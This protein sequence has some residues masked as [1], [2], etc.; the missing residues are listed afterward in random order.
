VTLVTPDV[1]EDA[2]ID[3]LERLH[4]EHLAK[5]ERDRGLAARTIEK[6]QTVD[7]LIGDGIRL[8]ED[9]PPAALLGVFGTDR[10]PERDKNHRLTF[11]W[12]LAV[13]VTVVGTNRRDVIKRRSWYAMTV[14]ECLLERLPRHADPIDTLELLDV[15]FTNGRT[16]DARPRTVGEA[17]I[18]L[19]VRIR[20]SMD[21]TD[22]PPSDT[23]L[24]PGTPGGPP[25]EPYTPPEPWPLASDVTSTVD[26][27]PL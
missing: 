11:I 7:L 14:A 15:D 25:A 16:T 17:Q 3:V 20:E 4:I 22:L 9:K 19:S 12:T 2:A 23:P 26:K 18:L 1:I 10:A 21:L 24:E 13:Q 5:F 8:R 6:L 27:E